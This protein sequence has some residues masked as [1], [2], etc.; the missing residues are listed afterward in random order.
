MGRRGRAAAGRRPGG[1][2]A[3]AGDRPTRP[4][5]G[6]RESVESF[7]VVF[8]AFLVWSFEAEGFVIPTGS[9][10]PTL[11]GRHKDVT[12]PECGSSYAVNAD[13]ESAPARD[14]L[15]EPPRIIRGT[16]GNC[17]Y[18]ADVSDA[19]SFSGDRIYVMKQ[20]VALPF[21]EGAGRVRLDRWDVAVFKL[22]EEP[23]VRYIKRLVGMPGE[24]LRV[25]SGDIW[26][27]TAGV[28]GPFERAFR[29]LAHQRAMQVPVFDDRHRPAAL[30]GD[31]AWRRWATTMSDAWTEPAGP[32]RAVADTRRLAGTALPASGPQPRPVGGDPEGSGSGAAAGEPDHGLLDVQH[33]GGGDRSGDPVVVVDRL[34]PAELGRR[35]GGLHAAGG[36]R[37]SGWVRWS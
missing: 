2:A 29:P 13:R 5:S 35:P 20:G 28:E 24:V 9:M 37:P 11:M 18:E 3:A 31:P 17:R 27:R 36:G 32:V 33:G 7:V 8:M 14:G 23:E 34:A 22:P 6:A 12:C 16:C 19:P 10:A 30:E 25:R 15:G 21:F 4:R 26:I 1:E